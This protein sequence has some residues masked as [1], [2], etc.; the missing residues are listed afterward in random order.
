[1]SDDQPEVKQE[2]LVNVEQAPVAQEQAQETTE[3]A[4]TEV[5]EQ[6]KRKDAEHNFAELRRQREED[7]RRAEEAERIANEERRRTNEILELFKQQKA[8]QTPQERDLI[9]EELAKLSKEDLATIDHVDKKIDRSFKKRSKE[10][11]EVRKEV[12]ALKAQLEEERFRSKFPDLDEVLSQDNIEMLKKEDP[13]MA[14]LI[15][16]IKN[17]Q[18][19]AAMAYKYIKRIMPTKIEEPSEKKKALENSKKPLSVQAI[20]K[21]SAIGNAQAFENGLTKELKAQL[22]KEM[23][24]AIKR[25]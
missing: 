16:S 19:Q 11:E 23:Q 21:T 7:R 8:A 15:G 14:R 20:S 24:D 4:S 9:E 2:E 6:P 22:Y 10:V 3:E 25:G 12:E 1:M 13:E 17:T 18:E 5:K